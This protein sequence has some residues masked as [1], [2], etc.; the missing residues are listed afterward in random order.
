MFEPLFLKMSMV[1]REMA[2]LLRAFAA[3]EEHLELSSQA[4]SFLT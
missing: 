3:L 1:W 2:Q 4:H